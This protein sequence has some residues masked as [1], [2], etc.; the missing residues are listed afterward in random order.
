METFEYKAEIQELKSLVEKRF[1]HRLCTTNDF[2]SL[3]ALLLTEM[4]TPISTSTLKR[5]WQYVNDEHVPRMS[6]LDI[7]ARY[8]GHA[9]FMAF[10]KWQKE[11][12]GQ[13]SAFFSAER[14]VASDLS[15]GNE[16]EIGWA[17]NRLVRLCH[18]GEGMFEVVNVH[19]SKLMV[20]DLLPV[21]SFI[22]GEP[23]S[24]PYIIRNGENTLPF[25]AGKN[26]GLTILS[27]V[28]K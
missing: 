19:E 7:L 24:V 8:V 6:T 18:K 25:V 27:L 17:P 10:C 26:G 28:S 14:I 20:G 5:I 1:C 23:L 12:A 4:K 22:L 9:D 11:G 13:S 16:V 2:E 21:A 15:I 3:S